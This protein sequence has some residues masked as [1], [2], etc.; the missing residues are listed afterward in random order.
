MFATSHKKV[1]RII[2]LENDVAVRVIDGHGLC[3]LAKGYFEEL[4]LEINSNRAPVLN[5]IL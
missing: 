3:Q 2:S 5:S 4:F 1:N